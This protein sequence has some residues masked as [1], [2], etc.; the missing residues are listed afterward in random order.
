MKFHIHHWMPRNIPLIESLKVF[1]EYRIDPAMLD[2]PDDKVGEVLLE[3]S[4]EFDVMLVEY[5][6]NFAEE[7]E[8]RAYRIHLDDKGKRFRQR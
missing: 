8:Q 7:Q 4:K 6:A 2:I 5:E 3:L 1:A